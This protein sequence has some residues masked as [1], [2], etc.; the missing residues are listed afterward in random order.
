MQA[1]TRLAG[2]LV[3]RSF[4]YEIMRLQQ[5]LRPIH[6]RPMTKTIG[7]GVAEIKVKHRGEYRAFYTVNVGDAIYI[8]NAFRK[9]T[10]KT[11]RAEIDLARARFAEL[12]QALRR[13]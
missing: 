5:G 6:Y 4:G 7:A 12:K 9:K 10:Q 13:K 2:A 1:S 11:P 8:I 3:P